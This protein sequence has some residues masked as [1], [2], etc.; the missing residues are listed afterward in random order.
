MIRL[1]VGSKREV[2]NIFQDT[3]V[4]FKASAVCK[5]L[6]VAIR[7]QFNSQLHPEHVYSEVSL[8]LFIRHKSDFK[9]LLGMEKQNKERLPFV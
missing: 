7:R 4:K 6:K 8:I 3:T 1:D 2:K 5:F 9:M